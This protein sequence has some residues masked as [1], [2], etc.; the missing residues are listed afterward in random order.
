MAARGPAIGPIATAAMAICELERFLVDRNQF[1]GANRLLRLGAAGR[2]MLE[3]RASAATPPRGRFA[4]PEAGFF[5]ALASLRKA[6]DAPASLRIPRLARAQNNPGQ[7]VP[8]YQDPLWARPVADR[9][10]GE[11]M[12]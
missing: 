6:C 9:W 2:A 7:M 10:P 5:R 12:C 1:D 8:I 11:G 3:H 4:P